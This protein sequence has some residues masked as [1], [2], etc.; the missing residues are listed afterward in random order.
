MSNTDESIQRIMVKLGDANT[1]WFFDVR[2]QA[3]QARAS[4]H[5][6][7][8]AVEADE[9][10][11]ALPPGEFITDAAEFRQGVL[12]AILESH[13]LKTMFKDQL[14]ALYQ[15]RLIDVR[16]ALREL[17]WTGEQ[18]QTLH[19]GDAAAVFAFEHA[20]AGRNVVGM[21]I[22]GVFDD[23]TRTV[24]EM[25][26][27][28]DL[29]AERFMLANTQLD[30]L[31]CAEDGSEGRF[32][33][34]RDP[35]GGIGETETMWRPGETD[36]AT[37]EVRI[38]LRRYGRAAGEAY[39]IPGGVWRD[40][41]NYGNT[42][43]LWKEALRGA[44]LENSVGAAYAEA[45]RIE[46]ESAFDAVQ[47][48][49]NASIW[50]EGDQTRFNDWFGV[51]MIHSGTPLVLFRG[52]PDMEPFPEHDGWYGRGI[53]FVEHSAV[54][55][56]EARAAFGEH[57][58]I[59]VVPAHLRLTS[60]YVFTPRDHNSASNVQLMEELGFS[61]DEIN[62]AFQVGQS[63]KIIRDALEARGHD[64]LVVRSLADGNEYVAFRSSQVLELHPEHVAVRDALVAEASRMALDHGDIGAVRGADPARN[65]VY[66]GPIVASTPSHLIQSVGRNSGVTHERA[67]FGNVPAVGAK[68][69]VSYEGGRAV[70]AALRERPAGHSR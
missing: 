24:A 18:Y 43:T 27:E 52:A 5:R 44:S 15:E 6:L 68:V 37:R 67:R 8:I 1:S 60:P 4:A 63:A 32:Q 3:E 61:Q 53:Y 12:L 50:Q 46:E 36:A 70:V 65:E 40:I 42:S 66:V 58:V 39:A 49:S 7:G 20:G 9:A 17:G 28:A 22:N 19:R 34:M 14:D 48:L 47:H 54:A 29:A 55:D 31:I 21:T 25:A 41:E 64:G 35:S 16:N 38:R 33:V 26:K 45:R 11:P 23:L 56:E 13:S 62:D 59:E 2:E 10:I 51:S 30:V 69:Q 57:A